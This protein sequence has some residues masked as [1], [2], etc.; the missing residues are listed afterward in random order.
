MKSILPF[1][2]VGT[3]VTATLAIFALAPRANAADMPIAIHGAVIHTQAGTPLTDGLV[4]V[5]DG[6]ITYVGTAKDMVYSA[7]HR[8]IRA[9][10][11]TPGLI[12][13][14]AT[15][16]LSGLLNQPQDQDMLERSHP[17]Q[18]ELR[19]IDAYNSQDPLVAYLRGFGITTLN[20]GHAPG[21]LISGQTMIIKTSG[22]TADTDV[23]NTSAMTSVSLGNSALARGEGAAGRSPGTRAKAVAMLR[24]ELIKTQEYLVKRE[25][26]DET[27]RVAQISDKMRTTMARNAGEKGKT[28]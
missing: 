5:R 10:V 9:A 27:K 14:R 24:A 18:P 25:G 20:T 26:K 21:A 11:V 15:A 2:S 4:L 19:A 8:V 12:D 22:G 13:A 7:D 16:G 17:V 23:I 3:W 1:K 6:K 28:P